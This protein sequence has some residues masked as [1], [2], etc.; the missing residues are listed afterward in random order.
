M[1]GRLLSFFFFCLLF[2]VRVTAQGYKWIWATGGS[3][4]GDFYL[5]C[6]DH[7]ENV[8]LGG[9]ISVTDT[10]D[11]IPRAFWAGRVI[12]YDSSGKQLWTRRTKNGDA[13][14]IGMSTDV[15][16][17]LYVF[18]NYT[19]SIITLD[20]VT[21]R[22]SDSAGN[23]ELFVAKYTTSGDVLWAINIANTG[24]NASIFAT[25]VGGIAVNLTSVYITAPFM[26]SKINVGAYELVNSNT[27][28]LT[29]D[30][31]LAK[32]D[33]NGSIA[34]AES[35]G[36]Q[37]DD[38][39]CDIAVATSG[40][41]YI[42]GT[43]TSPFLSF[44]STALTGS[45][46]CNIF[47][48]KHDS[49]GNLLWVKSSE[50]CAI[51]ANGV[52]TDN[53]EN[54]YITGLSA[55]SGISFGG[56]E[57][58]SP[59]GSSNIFLAKYLSSGDLQWA[60]EIMPDYYSNKCFPYSIATD[61]CGDVWI[62]GSVNGGLNIDGDLL[63]RPDGSDPMFFSGFNSNGKNI[64]NVMLASGGDDNNDIAIDQAGNI[65]VGGDYENSLSCGSTVLPERTLENNFVAKY[66]GNLS[67]KDTLLENNFCIATF[68]NAF[69]P[70][71]DGKNDFFYPIIAPGC[72]IADYSF[73]IYNRWGQQVFTTHEP[74]G[75]WDGSF[76]SGKA[77]L[78]VYM[79][80]L[81]YKNTISNSKHLIKGT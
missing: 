79:Y 47:L 57:L 76:K 4:E 69:T 68:P 20:T 9:A 44:G 22:N 14:L 51:S 78:D 35:Y 38:I 77:D 12:K 80:Y 18:G 5:V 27:L 17:N 36:G 31:L 53:G 19:D 56:H 45:G 28:G 34:W 10:V 1:H 48:A 64:N 58:S 74:D 16:D 6:V 49:S 41:S 66:R 62:S 63:S 21:L 11:S 55:S 67:C 15:Q 70:N 54:A 13:A 7:G 71:D 25:P 40:K 75:K 37:M 60:K 73:S 50:G 81:T 39:P 72:N 3:I 26:K 33:A 42:V 23:S 24:K 52:A 29:K 65:Y 59:G 46:I 2:S 8:Y 32:I 30:I 43:F 61:E